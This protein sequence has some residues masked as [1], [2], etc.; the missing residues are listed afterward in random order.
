MENLWVFKVFY[1]SHNPPVIKPQRPFFGS[2][3]TVK[4]PGWSLKNL[5][6]ALIHRSHRSVDAHARL[7]EFTELTRDVINIPPDY[8]I[9]ILAGSATAAMECALW[10]LLG[11][12]T[13]DVLHY[14]VFSALWAH[15]IAHELKLKHH[16]YAAPHGA[17]PI[18]EHHPDHDLVLNANGTTAGVFIPNYD[19]LQSGDGLVLLDATSAA[20]C[21]DL[22]WEK[23]DAVAFSWQKA[24]GGEAAHGMLVL[25]PRALERLH[26]DTPSWGIPR[27]LRLKNKGAINEGVF[28]GKPI[29]T[30]SMLCVEDMLSSL[31]WAKS[32]GGIK[33]LEARTRANFKVVSDF[34]DQTPWARFLSVDPQNTSPIS[35]CFFLPEFSGETEEAQRQILR[36]MAVPIMENKAGFDFIN[37]LF[38]P[39]SFRIWCGPTVDSSDVSVFLDWL[40]WSKVSLKELS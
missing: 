32:I 6:N 9:A 17:L 28:L 35:P 8:K 21:I 5:E 30:I 23:F 20:G 14:D 22:P 33:A 27:L 1:P 13:V 16:A 7:M 12:K 19:W 40:A 4:H 25:S 18:Y 2:G 3:P 38:A 31:N 10:N 11:P 15:D 24:F 34:V 37:H 36:Q 26:T 29:T 39:P